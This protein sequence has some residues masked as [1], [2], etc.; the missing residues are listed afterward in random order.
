VWCAEMWRLNQRLLIKNDK[1]ENVGVRLLLCVNGFC[2]FPG[3]E[4]G[5]NLLSSMSEVN[6]Y[7]K[8]K[9]FLIY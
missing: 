9:N 6:D 8:Q 5:G 7:F 2:E 1:Y 4:V 3:R